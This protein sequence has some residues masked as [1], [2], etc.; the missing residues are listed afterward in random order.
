MTVTERVE[1]AAGV[2]LE[3]PGVPLKIPVGMVAVMV[4][5]DVRDGVGVLVKGVVA[6]AD[7]VGVNVEVFVAVGVSVA[8]DVLVA[9]EVFVGVKVG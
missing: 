5:V 6:V 7:G 8:V 3:M 4:G 2:R 9:V 1:P